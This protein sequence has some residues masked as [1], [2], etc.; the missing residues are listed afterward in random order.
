MTT[1]ANPSAVL[2][3]LLRKVMVL[4]DEEN[5]PVEVEGL[6][7]SHPELNVE[8][9][10]AL[11]YEEFCLRRD[12]GEAVDPTEYRLRF[13]TLSERL[14][15]L[16]DIHDLLDNGSSAFDDLLG[17]DLDLEAG[18]QSR[19]HSA[20]RSRI[21][22]DAACKWGSLVRFPETSGARLAKRSSAKK[23]ACDSA[24]DHVKSKEDVDVPKVGFVVAPAPT[25][26]GEDWG[27]RGDSLD[28]P[29]SDRVGGSR[30]GQA[31]RSRGA[32]DGLNPG[33]RVAGFRLVEFLGKGSFARVFL[34][35]E[36]ELDRDVV[37]KVSW[38]ATSEPRALGRLQH[39]HIVPIHS[40]R[41]DAERDLYWVCMPYHGRV[42]L[43]QLLAA[44]E[45]D[46]FPDGVSILEE[47]DR[48]QP[49]GDRH[50]DETRGVARRRLE[51]LDHASAMAWW[52]AR[53][54]EGLQHAHDR[55]L[56]HRDIKPSN[57][58]LTFDALPMLLDFNLAEDALALAPGADRGGMGGTVFY[59]APEQL[60]CHAMG[61]SNWKEAECGDAAPRV[62]GRADLYS[63]GLVLFEAI[64]GRRAFEPPSKSVSPYEYIQIALEQRRTGP[65]RLR[66]A[67]RPVPA[68]LRAILDKALASRP[69]DRYQTALEMAIDLQAFVD[70]DPLVYAREAWRGRLRRSIRRHQV[71]LM[72]ATPVFL[73][74]AGAIAIY[75][76][77]RLTRSNA[78]STHRATATT[79]TETARALYSNRDFAGA[80]KQ[81]EPIVRSDQL[82]AA[83]PERTRDEVFQMWVKAQS[84]LELAEDLARLQRFHAQ[85]RFALLG[86]GGSEA[87]RF[88]RQALGMILEP[89]DV[90]GERAEHVAPWESRHRL[91]GG[92]ELIEPSQRA[93]LM[94]QVNELLFLASLNQSSVEP[95][96]YRIQ[97]EGERV[98]VDPGP[99]RALKEWRAGRLEHALPTASEEA[100]ARNRPLSCF[101]WGVLLFRMGRY[102]LASEWLKRAVRDETDTRDA[103]RP[104]LLAECLLRLDRP[105]L[106]E[107]PAQL[108]VSLDPVGPWPLLIRAEIAM[109]MGRFDQAETDLREALGRSIRWKSEASLSSGWMSGPVA[110]RSIG[111]VPPVTAQLVVALLWGDAR[112]RVQHDQGLLALQ[113]HQPE[114]A[115]ERFR[116]VLAAAESSLALRAKALGHLAEAY[117]QLGLIPLADETLGQLIADDQ[118]PPPLRMVA[119]FNRARLLLNQAVV[120]LSEDS[121]TRTDPIDHA[122]VDRAVEELRQAFPE[123]NQEAPSALAEMDGE[124]GAD[125]LP[126]RTTPT[127]SSDFE[128]EAESALGST[129][130][131]PLAAFPSAASRQ[132]ADAS[133]LMAQALALR[134]E[135]E[136][137]WS[138]AERAWQLKPSPVHRRL[139]DRL[140]AGA[141]RFERLRPT[142]AQAVRLWYR[143]GND[144][145]VDLEQA[146]DRLSRQADAPTTTPVERLRFRLTAAT[147]AHALGRREVVDRQLHLALS[148]YPATCD[149]WLTR[150]R[151]TLDRLEDHAAASSDSFETLSNEVVTRPT[152]TAIRRSSQIEASLPSVDP[153]TSGVDPVLA[154]E[155]MRQ[156]RDDLARA[157]ALNPD[158]PEVAEL[159]ARW[160]LL[161]GEPRVA[162]VRLSR[163]VGSSGSG[164][165]VVP[166]TLGLIQARCWLALNRPESAFR[167]LHTACRLDP[168][169]PEPLFLRVE[170]WLK[171]GRFREAHQD[172]ERLVGL[173]DGDAHARLR[174]DRLHQRLTQAGMSDPPTS[175][176]TPAPS[177]TTASSP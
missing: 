85:A 144:P 100:N 137:G 69:S 2:L 28:R 21:G 62:D 117:E 98:A 124:G 132:L 63:L 169:N 68:A 33:D 134:G 80:V 74:A 60:E 52:V 40:S 45:G 139:A 29:V 171:A 155:L 16:F 14:Q 95:L 122:R 81:L 3:A 121:Q 111:R 168:D 41:Y 165:E 79:L 1:K 126:A 23:E 31:R 163:L 65:P 112:L 116:A 154:P 76:E 91:A 39:T 118:V 42:T 115:V 176:A 145:R 156:V 113:L 12:R 84:G 157:A 138:F 164:T 103:L 161:R 108:A 53:L 83:L 47:L 25:K 106:A 96:A 15:R 97:S 77:N 48:L 34:A 152:S 46:R 36:E 90:L 13:P 9:R 56:L 4:S 11:I 136:R 172:L 99:W 19:G 135:W 89:F 71:A 123:L 58:L 101:Q 54:A 75:H 170:A 149:S 142:T 27:G 159:S 158:H 67:D 57:I 38:R 5:R 20:T 166:P 43:E 6:L 148:E 109:R 10:V 160:W 50:L 114:R 66:R 22:L 70:G 64:T 150:A 72:V 61:R 131:F 127:I 32:L 167:I 141:G 125:A 86:Y 30:R 26:D 104:L 119:R 105:D 59:M 93:A 87:G 18:W 35:R 173:I 51:E 7:A 120:S 8:A 92:S 129:D 49:G 55:G 24:T 107:T 73:A 146:V 133:A 174:W 147:L 82:Q 110:L 130:R 88:A 143:L 78:E 102:D 37:L 153:P 128:M 140:A 162:L 44:L 177:H 151:I 94:A 175:A 17:S